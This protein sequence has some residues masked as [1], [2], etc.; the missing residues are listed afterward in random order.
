[1][2]EPVPK[3]LVLALGGIQRLKVDFFESVLQQLCG[4]ATLEFEGFTH[5][6]WL[7]RVAQLMQC[8]VPLRSEQMGIVVTLPLDL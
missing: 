7:W 1:M 2:L 8:V 4:F 6:L 3:E 5:I